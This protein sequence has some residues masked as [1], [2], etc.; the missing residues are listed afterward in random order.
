MARLI[1]KRASI[2]KNYFAMNRKPK[3]IMRKLPLFGAMALFLIISLPLSATHIIGGEISYQCLGNNKYKVALDVFRDCYFGQAPFDAPAHISVFNEAGV[4]VNNINV[5]PLYTEIIPN[6]ISN[7]PCLFPPPTI[8]V[9]HARYEGTVTLNQPGGFYFVYQR[10]CRNE[11]ITNVLMPDS[12]GATYYIYL[13]PQSRALCNSSPSFTNS[14]STI[15]T[16]PPVFVCVNKPFGHSYTAFDKESDSLVYKFYTPFKGASITAPQPPFASPPM[17]SNPHYQAYDTLVWKDPPYNLS[18]LLGPSSIATLQVNP[19]TGQL[20]AYPEISGQFVVGVM[21]EEYRNGQLLSVLRREFQYNVGDCALLD[22]QIEAPAA[23][24]DNL[25]VQFGNNTAVAQNFV[26]YF[27]WPNPTP[28]STAFEP[29]YTFPDTGTYQIALVAEPVGQCV[30]TGFHQIYLQYNSLTADFSFQ[31][32]D[33]TSESVLALHDL[34]TDNVSPPVWWSWKV[35]YGNTILTSSQQNPVFEIP[36]PSNGTIMLTVRSQNGCEQT[37]TL[38]FVTGGNDPTTL[39]PDTLKICIG[40][41]VHLNPNAITAGFTYKWGPN[42][43]ANQQNLPNP[44]VTPLQTTTYNVTITGYNGLCTSTDKVTVQVFPQVSLNFEAD[45]DCDARVVHFVNQSQ[46]AFSGYV[47]NFGDPSTLLDVSTQAT[48]TYIYP[49]YGT[50]TVTLMTAPSAVCKDTIQKTITLTEKIL[51]AAFSYQYTSCEE[52]AVTVKFFD[53]TNNSLANTTSWKWTFSGVFNGTSTQKNPTIVVTQEGNLIVTLEVTTDENCVSATVPATLHIDLTELP[54]IIDGSEVLGCLNGGVILNPGGDPGYI[55]H[56]TPATGLSCSDCPSPLA[57]PSQ[58]TT[59]TVL[60]QAVSAD[61]CDIIRQVTVE[62]PQ[63]VGLVASDDVLTCAPTALLKANTSLLPVT[64][65][66][67]NENGVQVAGS[68]SQLTVNVSG[69]DHYVVRATDPFG[70]HYY[71][72][73]FVAGGPANIE[74]VGDQIKCSDE[75]LDIF[76]TN[77]DPNDTLTWQWTPVSAFN[78]SVNVPDPAVI[79]IPGAQ[80]LYVNAVNQFGCSKLDS[81]YMAVVDVNNNLDFTYIVECNGSEVKFVNESTNA[82]NYSWNF[83]D[84]AATDDVSFLDNPTYTYPGPG[85]YVVALTM[86]FPLPECVDTIY[87]EVIIEETQFI[88]DFTYEYLGC[89]VDSIEVQFHDATTILQ[90]NIDITCWQW[91][92]SNGDVSDLPSPVFTVY[93]GQEFIVTLT[94]CTSNDCMSSRTKSLKLEFLQVNLSDTLVLCQGDSTFLNPFGNTS[95]EYHWFPATNISDPDIPNPKVWPTQTTTYTVEITNFSPD[96]CMVTRA[97]TVFVPEKIDVTAS[98]D[99]F[100]CGTPV[101]I[102]AN[103]NVSPTSFQW[104]ANP[105]GLVGN[106]PSLTILPSVDTEYKVTGVDQYGCKDSA[107]VFVA[108]E[109][110]KINWPTLGAECPQNEIPLTVTNTVADHNL[111]YTWTATPPGQILPPANGP[112]VMILTPP[113][114]QFATY[115][116]TA[117]NQFGCTRTLTQNINSFNFVPTVVDSL[118]ACAG[119]SEP[120][121]PGANPNLDYAWSPLGGL[122]NP[123]APNPIVTVSQTTIYTVT[124]SDNFGADVCQKIIEVEVFVPPIIDISETVD[125][126]TCGSPIVISAQTN[127]PVSVEWFNP[128]NVSLGTGNTL[129]VNPVFTTTYKVVA[130]DSYQCSASEEVTVANNQLDIVLDGNNG[131]IDT[132]PMV[133]YNLCITNLDPNDV[134]TFQWTASNGGTILAGGDT[135]CPTVATQQGVTSTFTA[136]VS[137]QWGCTSTEQFS[138]ATYTFDPI[139]RDVITICPG[140][141]TPI[142]PGSE[143]TNLSYKWSP[144][145]GLSC[146]DCPNPEATLFGTQLYQVTIEGYNFADTCSLVQTV[147]VLTTPPI[148]LVAIPSDTAICDPTDISIAAHVGS[149]IVTSYLWSQNPDFSSPFSSESQVTVTPHA[150]QNYYV[151]ATDTLGCTDTAVATVNAYP[152]DVTLADRYNFCEEESP[153]I[154]TVQ[155]NAP[156]QELSF[157]WS[158]ME[159]IQEIISNGI[160]VVVDIPDTTT[161]T[162]YVQNFPYGCKD[163][164][165]TNVFYYDIEPTVNSQI[166]SSEDT[167]IYNSGEFSQLE[168]N[169]VPGYTYQWAPEEGLDDP[170]IHNPIAMPDQ[171]TT[172][173]VIVTDEGNC[174]AAREVTVVVINPDCDEPF[175]FLPTAFTPNGDGQN[176][177]LFVRSNIV[178][179]V[180]LAI[181]NRWGQRVFTTTDKNIGWDGT[182]KGELQTPDVYG[183]YLKAKCFNGQEFF[184]KGNVTL[185]R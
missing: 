4:F 18:A 96:T 166:F 6:N 53:Q 117:T 120:L 159:Y 49:D 41:S 69:Y 64:Y 91:E 84:P 36:N 43:P 74:A 61:T 73:V 51:E 153:L 140:V 125:T 169:F 62:V 31:T 173:T 19:Q 145:T 115:T 80:W 1:G 3:N 71:D 65:S 163:T 143:P 184:K 55:Y 13:S 102:S 136:Q 154:I 52:G 20:T 139:I 161:F 109:S 147:Q 94:I 35:T 72:T 56:W 85:T 86:N 45:T 155:N 39:L 124:V 28:S 95:Y 160:I 181:Y 112:S 185:L 128:Q 97:V 129:Q 32:Y 9:E 25:T 177:V 144:Q 157:Q 33:C 142:N 170:T 93:N 66:W 30:D 58:T 133:S 122:S 167:I 138:V 87:K 34:S 16:T 127:P 175:I 59:Y 106:Q 26:W 168:I 48:P 10:C 162:A 116:V 89:D 78:G 76:A 137:N 24:C 151:M 148:D 105:G 68:V 164:I 47:W 5:A 70:C 141:P 63:N 180:E 83:G 165:S 77:L 88:V 118:Q 90:D 130:T 38:N 67:F 131:V 182:F 176:D 11:T 40:E 178:D 75:P 79:V 172:Y 111:T 42:V 37:K 183:Y 81:V 121:N 21:V 99:T 101:T 113:A 7:D 60:V 123:N 22:V 179:T 114:N 152:I 82:Y 174:Q 92:T 23:Q 156:G 108:N 103:S 132:C 134:L 98:N 12:T 119:V 104:V 146:Y 171:T 17:T 8:C 29:V 14:T 46:N 54:G 27:D 107:Y 126:F 135:D 110:V 57:N 149:G 15:T 100:T 44:T 2:F 50:Y 150:T 158:P